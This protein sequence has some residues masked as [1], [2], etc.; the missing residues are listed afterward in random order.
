M[1]EENLPEHFFK[2]H[3]LGV[4]RDRAG[5][6]TI[7]NVWHPHWKVYPVKYANIQL[8]WSALYGPQFHFLQNQNPDSV[9]FA[10]GSEIKVYSKEKGWQG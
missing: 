3:E 4:G 2:E 7:Y 9:F 8:D 10:E 5:K 6:T 1:P